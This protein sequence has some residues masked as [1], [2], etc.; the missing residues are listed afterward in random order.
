MKNLL[1]GFILI[2]WSISGF[3][4][5]SA[6][7][8]KIFEPSLGSLVVDVDSKNS[9]VIHRLLDGKH[10]L[11]IE[12]YD[13]T[14]NLSV[15]VDGQVQELLGGASSDNLKLRSHEPPVSVHCKALVQ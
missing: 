2:C 4:A 10:Y 7:T 14:L 12:W 3:A 11:S 13:W 15:H 9:V 5:P 8:C 6:Y 1:I